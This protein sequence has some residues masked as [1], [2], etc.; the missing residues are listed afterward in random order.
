MVGWLVGW[1]DGWLVGWLALPKFPCFHC[2][3]IKL[4]CLK[5]MWVVWLCSLKGFLDQVVYVLFVGCLA[6]FIEGGCKYSSLLLP[7]QEL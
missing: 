2:S 6:L 7:Y 1:L 5:H 4:L 3:W